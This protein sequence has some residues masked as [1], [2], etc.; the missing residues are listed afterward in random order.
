MATN[1]IHIAPPIAAEQKWNPPALWA[2]IGNT[3]LLPFPDPQGALPPRVKVFGKAEWTN[4]GGSVKDRPAAAILRR[5][6]EQGRLVGNRIFLDSTS[7]N[8]GIAYATLAAPLGLP[9][10]LAIPANASR[11]RLDILRALGARLTLT[12][13]TEG[14][15]GAREVAARMARQH[16]GRYY[17]ADQYSNP[18]NWQAHYHTT[19]P[20]ILT[21]TAG[22]L[23]HFVA[24]LGTTGTLTGA[25]RFLREAL[26]SVS[27]VA[28][29][30]A[31]PLH[32]LEG[33]KHLKT[34]PVPEIYDP[35]LPDEVVEV[36]TEETYDLLKRIARQQG[37]LLGLSAGA[38]LLAAFRVARRLEE[39]LVVAVLP[40]SAGKYLSHPFWGEA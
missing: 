37:R 31:E 40:D 5:A 28:V 2:E 8:M 14:S 7:G 33:L 4:P 12:D 27:I 36:S 15:D 26:D 34:S 20:E 29:Q 13:P 22:G 3:P 10:H 18:A 21:Q 39:G 25:G 16:P 30:P 35:G 19:G 38:A 24:G 11:E 17:Y 6:I 23:T 32:G 1:T 9:I